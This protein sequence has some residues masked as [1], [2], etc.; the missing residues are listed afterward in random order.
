MLH[1]LP[2][3]DIEKHTEIG[4]QCKCNPIVQIYDEILVIHNS[5]DGREAVEQ[6]QTLLENISKE[7]IN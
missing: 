1:I 6:A 3:N 5:F 2:I 7:L 4:T